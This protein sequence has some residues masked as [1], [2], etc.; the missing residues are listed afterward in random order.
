MLVKIKEIRSSSKHSWILRMKEIAYNL[1]GGKY[2]WPERKTLTSH[3]SFK[4]RVPTHPAVFVPWDSGVAVRPAGTSEMRQE[5]DFG[6][7]QIPV[8]RQWLELRE[9]SNEFLY[10]CIHEK[11]QRLVGQG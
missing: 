7:Q 8:S 3:F 4:E 1:Q 5:Y 10:A 9:Q 11:A 6:T 2:I